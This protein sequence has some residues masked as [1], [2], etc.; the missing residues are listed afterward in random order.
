MMFDIT[1]TL[2]IGT[3]E[4][5]QRATF[6]VTYAQS[7]LVAAQIIDAGGTAMV[8]DEIIARDTLCLL[9]TD[10]DQISYL[11]SGHPQEISLQS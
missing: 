11:F 5:A 10:G 9:G 8:P 3:M 6:S 2:K 1:P 7:A 4:E